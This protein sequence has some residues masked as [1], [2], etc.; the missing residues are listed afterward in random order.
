MRY[1]HSLET[2]T[3]PENGKFYSL[4]P[5]ASRYTK[6]FAGAPEAYES[7]IAERLL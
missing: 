2:L 1:I 5:S 3:I 4:T 6:L 7:T